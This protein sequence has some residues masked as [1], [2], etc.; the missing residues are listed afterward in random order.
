MSEIT[1]IWLHGVRDINPRKKQ[2][3]VNGI[4]R[5]VGEVRV[6][7]DIPEQFMDVIKQLAQAALDKKEAEIKA[8]LLTKET[9]NDAA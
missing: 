9:D 5:G 1:S 3:V 6:K 2:A 7:L 8:A 4:I